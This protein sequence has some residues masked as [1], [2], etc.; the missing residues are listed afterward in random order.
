MMPKVCF[1]ALLTLVACLSYVSGFAEEI[2][3]AEIRSLD[4]QVQEIKSDVLGIAAELDLLEE[5]LLFP[6]ST[7][8]TIFVVLGE[9]EPFRLDAVQLGIDD[10]LA[11]HHIYSF[12]ELEALQHGGVQRIYMGN[13]PAGTHN[14]EVSM[15]GK[16]PNGKD[17][18]RAERFTFDKGIEPSLLGITLAPDSGKAPIELQDW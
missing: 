7:Q 10:Q 18:S 15:L 14:L 1:A 3:Q 11:A 13:L 6:S 16:L 4:E 8:V 9:G 17:F 12:K 5:R 2:S